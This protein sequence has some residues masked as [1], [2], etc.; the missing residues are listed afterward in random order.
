MR[1]WEDWGVID[2]LYTT[3]QSLDTENVKEEILSVCKRLLESGVGR[4]RD[5][6][7]TNVSGV[8]YP[9]RVIN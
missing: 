1:I 8:S 2:I 3:V 6:N 4:L 7:D 9:C 5:G